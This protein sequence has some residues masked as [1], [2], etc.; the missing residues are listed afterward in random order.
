MNKSLW[1]RVKPHAIAFGIFF[2]VSC[3]Y[4]LPAFKGLVVAQYD[5]SG[6]MGMAQQSLEF[7]EKYGHFP[8]W[9]NAIFSGMPAFQIAA[10]SMHNIT[11]AHLHHLFTL[12]LPEPAGLFF[13]AC[14]GCYILCMALGVRS[15]IA[16]LAGLAY[17]FASYNAVIVSVGHTTKF[18]AMGYAP[19]VLAGL[20]LLTQRR[21]LLGFITTLV[22]STTLFFQNHVQI[23][24]YTLLMALCLGVAYAIE[25]IRQKQWAHLGKVFGLA[26]VA[27]VMGAL[28]FA[29]LLFPTYDYSRETMRGGRSELVSANKP[30]D[31]KSKGGLDKDYA[32]DYS[33]GITEVLTIVAPRIF[34]GSAAE[35]PENSKVVSEFVERTGSSEER[36]MQ[37]TSNFFRP[38]WGPQQGTAGAVYFGAALCLLFIF[39][40]V[41]YTGWHSHWLI[42][43]SVL[44]I[45]LAWGKSFPAVNY[46]LFDYLPFY[47]KFR[48][49]SMALVIPQLG[50]PV[51][52]ALGLNTILDHRFDKQV[53]WKKFKLASIVSGI[54]A[55][56]LVLLYFT[57]DYRS[58]TDTAA[59]T[60]LSSAML[61]QMSQQGQPTP[62]MQQ[63][64]DEFGRSIANAARDDRRSLYGS[65]LFRSIIFM[66]LALGLLYLY[67]K[68]KLNK[69]IF[70]AALTVLVFIDLIMI[71]LRYLNA[72]RYVDKEQF[73]DIF[74]P[75]AADLQIMQDTS[76][77]RVFN[78]D[79]DP[80]QLSPATSRTSYLHN[81]VGGYHPAKL[82]L[83]NDLIFQQL[84]KG[85]IQV[86]NMLNTKYFMSTNPADQKTVAQQNP[87][88][89]GAAWFVKAS[90]VV[91]NAN[92]EMRA[93]D[94]FHPRDTMVV[95]KR[96]LPK[97]KFQPT[98]DSSAKIQLVENVNDLIVYKSSSAKNG[99]AVFSE[100]YY[101]NGWTAVID[102]QETPIVKVN[103]L[104]RGLSIPAGTHTIEF[105][106]APA[107]F[108]IGD[109]ITLIIGILS[110][111]IL[112]Y[113]GFVLWKNYRADFRPEAVNKHS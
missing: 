57:L 112:L 56:V 70:L 34:G 102:G 48:A 41:Y 42:A 55:L 94:N 2:V 3:L 69:N 96:E 10:G 33:Y 80:F 46:F 64:A 15:R 67:A 39:G 75:T 11:I 84:V 107:S 54:L 44:G 100:I 27:G 71:D 85:N 8:L 62:A 74:T 61:Q 6:W 108:V 28:S 50:F 92:E 110:I 60:Q 32:F 79:G 113:G 22:F 98:A 105:R 89:L 24:Y 40:M 17:A 37:V 63:Q 87:D 66:A 23:A 21:Y 35:L 38:Y 51:M 25:A 106:F 59:R 72:D 20:V 14:G 1:E 4:C 43:A 78:S 13:L 16:I 58:E 9:T 26:V 111:L 52:A 5:A 73:T 99:F 45:I 76:Y 49:P 12:F 53:F 93:L 31:N 18:S 109:R 88:A 91:N 19:A 29:V 30:A 68:E 101:P 83:Y 95:D 65:D 104:L 47:N 90:K 7:K 36:A 97:I 103:Y 81:S 82:A 77:Y 86:F